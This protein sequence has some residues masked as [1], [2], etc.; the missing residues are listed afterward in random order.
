MMSRD[1]MIQIKIADIQFRKKE[2]EVRQRIQ[3]A[4][5]Q[6]E[7]EMLL[8]FESMLENIKEAKNE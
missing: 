2:L 5:N 6:K 4:E 8:L 7:Q 1:K 3:L